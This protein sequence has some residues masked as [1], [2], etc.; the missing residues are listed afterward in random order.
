MS[1]FVS[2]YRTLQ[3]LV[4]VSMTGYLFSRRTDQFKRS[5]TGYL[6]RYVLRSLLTVGVLLKQNYQK[7]ENYT[8]NL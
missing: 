6:K 3:C 2:H 5:H 4:S 1:Q 8:L 7:Y